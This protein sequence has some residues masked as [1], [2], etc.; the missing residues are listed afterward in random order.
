[1][2]KELKL[3]ATERSM[4]QGLLEAKS[5]K[6]IAFERGLTEKTVKTYMFKLVRMNAV[7]SRMEA[8]NWAR[9]NGVTG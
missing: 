3:T 2:L 1:M 8:A 9:A 7:H 4:L 5:N 6:L